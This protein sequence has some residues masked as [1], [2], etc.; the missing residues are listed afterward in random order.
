[1]NILRAGL[2]AA[3]SVG[4]LA[5]LP[6]APAS[7]ATPQC[8]KRLDHLPNGPSGGVWVPASSNN[9]RKCWM[10]RGN[11]SDGVWAL[12]RA[13]RICYGRVYGHYIAVDKD[14]GPETERALRWVQGYEGIRADGKYGPETAANI[15]F[16]S[17]HSDE[18]QWCSIQTF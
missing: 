11:Y 12:Q 2:A 16:S 15:R 9:V 1:M 7:A 6:A 10:Q 8:T 4:T 3:L 5:V 14:F 13:L 18:E 17:I